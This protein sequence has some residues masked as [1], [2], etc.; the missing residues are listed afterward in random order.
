MKVTTEQ[1]EDCVTNLIIE[2]DEDT[3]RPALQKVARQASNRFQIPGFRKGKAPYDVVVRLVG[4][5][6]LRREA[7]EEMAPELVANA[8]EEQEIEPYAQPELIDLQVNPLQLTVSVP[9]DPI[10]DLGDYHSISLERKKVEITDEDVDQAIEKMRRE[11]ATREP[12]AR[13]A[14]FGDVVTVRLVTTIEGEENPR[15][16]EVRIELLEGEE[17]SAIV[18]LSDRLVEMK[19]GEVVEF[20]TTVSEEHPNEDLAGKAVHVRAEVLGVEELSLPEVNDEF[21]I[22]MGDYDDLESLKRELRENLEKEATQNAEAELNNKAIES[23]VEQ[24]TIKYPAAIVESEIDRLVEDIKENMTSRRLSLEAYLK[25]MNLT[26]EQFREQQ[27]ERAERNVRT[28]LVMRAFIKAEGITVT[29]EELTGRIER[30]T[31][32]LV[33]ADPSLASW[34]RTP[35]FRSRMANDLTYNRAM[36]RL[37]SIVT[38]EPEPEEESLPL[39]DMPAAPVDVVEA[40]EGD[41]GEALSEEGDSE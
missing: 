22:M 40:S 32:N 34:I 30:V 41:E 23:L 8:L 39:E 3:L 20:D 26:E 1:I 19:M 18:G 13:P 29:D 2:V 12:V 16:E 5:E 27:R 24:A 37:I 21:A 25:A 38:G 4:E 28:V 36:R 14:Q 10:V 11:R 31:S 33:G 35:E 17:S 6:Y 9:R 15:Q 7:I